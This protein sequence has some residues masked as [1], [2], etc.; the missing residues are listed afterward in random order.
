MGLNRVEITL[1]VLGIFFGASLIM[2]LLDN[3]KSQ[4]YTDLQPSKVLDS[5]FYNLERNQLIVGYKNDSSLTFISASN[6]GSMR[7]SIS[8]TS[9]MLFMRDLKKE[10]VKIGDILLIER[11]GGRGDLTHRLVEITDEGYITKGDNNNVR[12][13]E[14]WKFSQIKGKIIGILY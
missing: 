9:V 13:K 4:C 1:F 7:P 12:D 5:W 3:S 6:T 10:D 11:G 2:L 14:I 8:D